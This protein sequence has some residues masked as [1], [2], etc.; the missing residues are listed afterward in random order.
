MSYTINGNS[1][2]D[3]N[4]TI[5]SSQG[6]L[7]IPKRLGEV[8]HNWGDSNG[9]EAYT[10]SDD[11]LWDG[12]MITLHG[13]YSGSDFISDIETMEA[14]LKGSDLTLVTHY[15]THTVRLARINENSQIKA[16]TRVFIDLEFW[17]RT[18]SPGTPPAATGGSGV[19]LG[20]YDFLQD[21]GLTVSMASGFGIMPEY[22]HRVLSYGNTPVS[23]SGNRANR[24]ARIVLAGHYADISTLVTNI[25]NLKSVLMSS[26][27]KS[28]VYR[29]TTK[30]V[31]FTDGAAVEINY[32][33]KIARIILKLKIQ[34]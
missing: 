27:T 24:T 6:A 29:G 23:F 3:Y 12:R 11:L 20:G 32:K 10:D 14:S 7:D 15:G 2:S 1:F 21:F 16:N 30:T 17:E 5:L 18:V 19:T 4:I 31:Y 28:L 34:E 33:A 25:N 13:Y 22:N 9:V 26:G 8:D